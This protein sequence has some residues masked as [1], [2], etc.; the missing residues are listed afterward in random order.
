MSDDGLKE[1]VDNLIRIGIALSSQQNVDELLEMIVD[2]SRRFTRADAGTLYTVSPD[3]S[4]LDWRIIQNDS[5]G[6]RVGG[7]SRVEVNPSVYKP[8]PL[9]ANGQV[10]LSNVSAYAA[11]TGQLVNIP[12][13][14]EAEGF[15]F[16]GPRLYDK[17]TGYR[18]RSMLVV[19]M[20][21]REGEV[22]GVLQLLN[23]SDG[24]RGDVVPFSPE[25]E[26]LTSSLASQAAVA[27]TNAQLIKE[28]RD[29]FDAFIRSIASAIDEKS[30]YTAG[31][32]K[33]VTDL[34]MM[35]AEEVNRSDAACWEHVHFGDAELEAL[36]ISAWM[37]DVGKITTPEHIVDKATK[38]SAIYDR[39]NA[40]QLRYEVMKRDTE[41][42][43]MREKLSLYEGGAKALETEEIDRRLRGALQDLDEEF[44]FL[45]R[46]N[47][48]SEFMDDE[49][50][51]R[52]R[53][54]GSRPCGEGVGD[55]TRLTVDEVHNLSIRKGTLTGEE[56]TVINNHVAVTIKILS[57]LPFSGQFKRVPEFAGGHHEKLNGRGYPA[58]L[59]GDQL[60]LQARL[61]AVADVFE[62]LTAPDRPYRKPMLLSGA[63]SILEDSA[64]KGEL[65]ERV[66]QLLVDSGIAGRYAKRELQKEQIDS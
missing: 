15:D 62:A 3:G 41:I 48:G 19:P 31:H 28:L 8:V 56:R 7:T 21:R 33:R 52:L 1:Q 58:G 46:C 61:M 44:G 55:L 35:L 57:Q 65:D 24:S 47:R 50:V 4:Q 45:K 36:R 63:L 27:I 23:A 10:N 6:T 54:I 5:L 53:E 49:D 30:P 34:T 42:A 14:Y 66:V 43:A 32:V 2:E 40:V 51:A 64:R 25:F 11:N 13:V 9:I 37:H 38:L 12:D 29:L 60:P 59:E 16:T 39:V 22:I 17:A 20:K 26:G 18:S